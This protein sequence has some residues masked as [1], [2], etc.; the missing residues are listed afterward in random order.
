VLAA[1][2]LVVLLAFA[3]F[4]SY[5][6]LAEA[7]QRQTGLEAEIEAADERIER[8]ERRVRRLASDPATLERVAREQLDMV[9]PGDVVIVFEEEPP[10][11]APDRTA[12]PTD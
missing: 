4:R 6:D 5:H 2:S 9:R 3:G 8:L 1:L 10:P 7:R 12:T 11:I